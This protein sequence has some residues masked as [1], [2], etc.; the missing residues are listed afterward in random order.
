MVSKKTLISC[1]R[2]LSCDAPD[3]PVIDRCL[4]LC[5]DY[6]IDEEAFVELWVVYSIQQSLNIIPTLDDLHKLEKEKLKKDK[7]DSINGV[8]HAVSNMEIDVQSN[9]AVI[10]N[11]LDIYNTGQCLASK[12]LKRVRSPTS[13]AE[14]DSKRR[15]VTQTFSPSTYTSKASV[16]NH[17]PS[18][19]ARGKILLHFGQTVETWKKQNEQNVSIVIANIP[20]M[21]KDGVY[22]YD[23][24]SKEVTTLNYDSISFGNRLTHVWKEMGSA[25]TNPRYVKKMRTISQVT[26]RIYGRI[27]TSIDKLNGKKLVFLEGY[28]IS[29]EDFEDSFIQLDLSGIKHYSVFP[30]Q[31]VV[32]EGTNATGK[33][34]LA[35]ELFVK[36]HVP[37]AEPPKLTEDLKVYVA[38][39]PFTTSG[40]LN[41]QPLWDLIECVV[42]DEPNILILIGPFIDNMHSEI[43]NCTLKESF[44]DFFDKI[45]SRIMQHLQGKHTRVI[46]ISSNRDVHHEAVYPTPE[47][48]INTNKIGSYSSNLYSMPDPCIINANGLQI[49]VTSVDVIRH[50][51]QYEVSNTS[52]M[53]RLS[54]LADHVLSQATFYPIYP[55]IPGLKLDLIRWRKYGCFDHQ[56][57]IMILPSDIKHYCKVV[58]ECLVLNPERLQKYIYA[59]LC[60][61]PNVIGKWDPNS[62]SCE[63]AKV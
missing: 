13:E 48:T 22:M 11:V 31:I 39:G 10:D 36:G 60:I 20:Y 8:Q 34:L 24:L 26:F 56:P 59:K 33:A 58:N 53:D 43:K 23:T 5:H 54:R 19:S 14:N 29:K 55:P 42:E 28:I 37:L 38:A 52:A 63:I 50:L 17:V 35:K 46:L 2:N 40:N 49:G 18:I 15:A 30:G 51:G 41:Y 1:F 16:P 4:Q 21:P 9:E 61:R 32:V 44:N 57:H 3:Q 45:L 25:D 47:Y 12:Q 62:V 6:G 27:F 7:T